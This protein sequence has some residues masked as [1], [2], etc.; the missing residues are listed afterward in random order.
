VTF[1]AASAGPGRGE[2]P[3]DEA[4]VQK[5]TELRDKAVLTARSWSDC[6]EAVGSEILESRET[7]SDRIVI[8]IDCGNGTRF[9][10]DQDEIAFD[11]IA[12]GGTE[13]AAMSDREAIGACEEKLK[14]GLAVPSSFQRLQPSTGIFRDSGEDVVVTFDFDALNGLGFPLTM[15]ARCLLDGRQ[16]IARL[17][18]TPR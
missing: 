10:L 3:A 16:E 6:E 7:R 15:Q 17:E 12:P 13:Q 11:R 8:R 14:L 18:V 4:G 2:R 9:Y 1:G 5:R